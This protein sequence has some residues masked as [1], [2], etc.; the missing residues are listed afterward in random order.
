MLD[1]HTNTLPVSEVASVWFQPQATLEI[2]VGPNERG[3]GIVTSASRGV[4]QE[5]VVVVVVVEEEGV[6]EEEVVDWRP[7]CPF[8]FQPNTNS[9]PS[10]VDKATKLLTLLKMGSYSSTTMLGQSLNL[11]S[12]ILTILLTCPN[13]NTLLCY[14]N[15][16]F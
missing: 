11:L 10:A 16:P 5:V 14:S 3:C 7:N 2:G 6:V 12:S 8:L 4:A 9:C 13:N 1:P 15:E